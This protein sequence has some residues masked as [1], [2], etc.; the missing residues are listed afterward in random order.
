MRDAGVRVA[1]AS[2][3]KKDELCQYLD[4]AAIADLVDVKTSSDDAEESKP[5]PDIFEV[6]LRKLGIAGVDTVAIGDTPYDAAAAGKAGIPT[7]GVR[8]AGGRCRSRS[9]RS[10]TCAVITQLRLRVN[11]RL[12]ELDYCLGC[13]R[14]ATKLTA[15]M[16]RRPARFRTDRVGFFFAFFR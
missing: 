5:A 10:S 4:I 3:A 16:R 1:V 6:V 7:V 12:T 11:E 13:G 14:P 8:A 2:P 9:L 15:Y